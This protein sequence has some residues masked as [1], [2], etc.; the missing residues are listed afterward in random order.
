MYLFC[1]LKLI[2]DELLVAY[3]LLWLKDS[4]LFTKVAGSGIRC[5]ETM[6]SKTKLNYLTR[7]TVSENTKIPF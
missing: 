4:R 6:L 7:S 3:V 1:I 5:Y 2:P